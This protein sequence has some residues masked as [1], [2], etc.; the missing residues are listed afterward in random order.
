M[1]PPSSQPR[2]DLA[3]LVVQLSRAAY[4][5]ASAGDLTPAQWLAL[6]FFSRAN[7]FS[8]TVSAFAEFHATTRGTASQTVRA[9]VQRGYLTRSRSERDGRSVQFDLTAQARDSLRND[10]LDALQ[11]AA[12]R[13]SARRQQALAE[14]LRQLRDW[15]AEER[16]ATTVG[17]CER[18]G[19][20][21]RDGDGFRCGL[22]DEP[23][24]S[25][26][27]VEFCVRYVPSVR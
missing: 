17:A 1:P 8:R 16:S 13:L 15:M 6:R 3:D 7:R 25:H 18:C 27:L 4:A 24:A 11:R 21:K 9:L 2:I 22:M 12:V 19:Y 10:P 23:L 20:L 5:E 26:E 14:D